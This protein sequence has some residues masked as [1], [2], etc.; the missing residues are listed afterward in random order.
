MSTR[1][2]R[3]AFIAGLRDLADRLERHPGAPLPYHISEATALVFAHNDDEAREAARC[4]GGTKRSHDV[5]GF[6]LVDCVPGLN[7][8]VVPLYGACERVELGTEVVIEECDACPVCGELIVDP[9]DG[10]RRCGST[11]G[12]AHWVE[13]EPD[14]RT[15]SVERTRWGHRCPDSLLALGGELDRRTDAVSAVEGERFPSLGEVTEE[16]YGRCEGE[17]RAPAGSLASED[18]RGVAS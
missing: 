5:H 6:A 1:P 11:A 2:D 10:P 16:A 3:T 15:V 7:L 14:R 13:H 17:N 8:Q 4:Y 12:A 18:N 9:D